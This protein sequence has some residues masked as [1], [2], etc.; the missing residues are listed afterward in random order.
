MEGESN[1]VYMTAVGFK[2]PLSS[3]SV[4][5]FNNIGIQPFKNKGTTFA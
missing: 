4:Y 3:K 2:W 5:P 1:Y